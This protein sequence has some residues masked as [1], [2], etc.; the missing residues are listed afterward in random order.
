MKLLVQSADLNIIE[1][2]WL[3]NVNWV[4]KNLENRCKRLTNKH[5][6]S[7]N[8]NSLF[9]MNFE[10]HASSKYKTIYKLDWLALI[11]GDVTSSCLNFADTFW[12]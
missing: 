12:N 11:F 5:F 4:P 2:V 8:K 9:K 10:T 3:E 6:S 7:G 1:N